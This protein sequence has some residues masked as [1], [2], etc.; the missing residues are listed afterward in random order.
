MRIVLVILVALLVAAPVA[1]A[2]EDVRAHLESTLP[3]AAKAGTTIT[4]KWRLYTADGKPFGAGELFVR[5]R[6]QGAV[7]RADGTGRDGRYSARVKVPRG[8]I[9]GIRFGLMGY[10]T[11]P[12]GRSEVAPVYFPLDNDPY[13]SR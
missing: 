9:R 8:G 7:T 1:S 6:G 13:E 12:D 10:R 4:V 11:Y 3:K 2:K 5:L